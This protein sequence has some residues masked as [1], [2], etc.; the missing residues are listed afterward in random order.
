MDGHNGDIFTSINILG[1][2]F[3][4]LYASKTGNIKQKIKR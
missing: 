3:T 1:D 2:F 4:K